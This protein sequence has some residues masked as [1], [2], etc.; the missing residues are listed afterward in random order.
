MAAFKNT[1][2]EGCW[3]LIR[4]A[5]H[6]ASLSDPDHEVGDLQDALIAAWSLMTHEQRT[7]LLAECE[8][9]SDYH[10][11]EDEDED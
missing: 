6:H 2:D 8:N 4:A 10:H 11:D 3:D 7:K 9:L 5:E 1:D